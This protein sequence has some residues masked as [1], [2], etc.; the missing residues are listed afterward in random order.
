MKR[1]GSNPKCRREEGAVPS[2]QSGGSTFAFTHSRNRSGIIVGDALRV[3]RELPESSFRCCITSPP[4]WG[5][6]DYGVCDQIGAEMDLDH[7]IDHLTAVFREVRRVLTNDGSF[8]LNIGD[9]Y[10][11][12]NRGWRDSDKKNPARGMSYRPP[13]PTGL[14]PKDLVGVPW[15]LAFALQ[16]DGWYLRSD[17]VWYKPNCQP[18]SVKDRPTRSHEYVFLLTKSEDY[19]YDFEAMREPSLTNG[20]TRNRR[21]VW[22]VNTEPFPEAHFATFP[23]SLIEPM[24]SAATSVGDCVLDPFLGSGTVGVVCQRAGRDFVGI[25]LKPEYAEIAL[26]RL[27]WKD[28]RHE[29]KRGSTRPTAEPPDLSLLTDAVPAQPIPTRRTEA[30]RRS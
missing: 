2:L 15:R 30:N 26:Y 17:I 12:G 19:Y 11:S 4:Y 21:T 9:V 7:Y 29:F 1:N 8:W 10:T 25:E 20:N 16:Q 5:V 18:E 23:P 27:G 13:T 22:S 14:K 3:L 24:V 6:R 28:L